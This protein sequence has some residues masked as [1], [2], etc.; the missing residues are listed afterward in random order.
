M[1]K[2]LQGKKKSIKKKIVLPTHYQW[3]AQGGKLGNSP[4]MDFFLEGKVE[5]NQRSFGRNSIFMKIKN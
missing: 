2:L 1:V 5:K 3:R 4:H